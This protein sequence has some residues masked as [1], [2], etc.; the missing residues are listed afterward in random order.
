M[1][2]RLIAR[3][4]SIPALLLPL[5]TAAAAPYDDLS[6]NSQIIGTDTRIEARS[7]LSRLGDEQSS[8]L[9]KASAI[10]LERLTTSLEPTIP[11]EL[12]ARAKCVAVFPKVEMGAIILGGA[13]GTGVI[14]CETKTPGTWSNPAFL[15]YSA[16]SVGP[17]VGVKTSAIVALFLNDTPKE[18]LKKGVFNLSADASVAVGNR[19]SAASIR[20]SDLVIYDD[21]QGAFV[22]TSLSVAKLSENK[23]LQQGFYQTDEPLRELIERSDI[24]ALSMSLDVQRLY[25]ALHKA[26]AD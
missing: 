23:E 3:I 2:T 17:Q 12:I 15:T 13:G 19:A 1:D 16:G 21:S 10:A 7:M 11:K 8:K 26:S 9:L 20:N 25:K 18:N 22:G 14:T 5:S 24:A 4:L 6:G